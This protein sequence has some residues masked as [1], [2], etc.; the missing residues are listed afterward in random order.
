MVTHVRSHRMSM[1][2]RRQAILDAVRQVFAQKGFH[3]TTTRE[4]AQAAGVSEALLFKHFPT[5]EALYAAMQ[6]SCWDEL[7][8]EEVQRL[9]N[10]EPSSG[11]L[12]Q[13]VQFLVTRILDVQTRQKTHSPK[14][15]EQ[16]MLR[17]MLEDGGFA[18]G[19]LKRFEES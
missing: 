10:I 13:L 9:R 8:D 3:G 7:E 17:S 12:V 15:L 4:L 1:D 2:E 11:A 5:K 16:L 19:F 14:F 6:A 18:R